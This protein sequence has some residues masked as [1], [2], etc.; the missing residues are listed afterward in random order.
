MLCALRSHR[1]DDLLRNVF[2]LSKRGQRR[3]FGMVSEWFQHFSMVSEWLQQRASEWF[4]NGFGV[5]SKWFP[6]GFRI[7]VSEWFQN[8]FR[9]V[10]EWLQN[11]FR[12][13]SR[14][15]QN[16]FEMV[17]EWF[18]KGFGMVSDWVSEWFQ[19]GFRNDD[20]KFLMHLTGFCSVSECFWN[21]LKSGF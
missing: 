6:N 13:A 10:S 16:R 5:V 8:G 12:T 3:A 21:V 1:F 15:F 14:W 7:T 18:Q 2:N 17:S 9:M 4:Q 19:T 11:G 20:K